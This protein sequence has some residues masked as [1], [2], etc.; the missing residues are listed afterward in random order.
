M[1]T[2]CLVLHKHKSFFA[3]ANILILI[4]SGLRLH[5]HL[6]INLCQLNHFLCKVIMY[7]KAKMQVCDLVSSSSLQLPLVIKHLFLQMIPIAIGLISCLSG[8]EALTLMVSSTSTLYDIASLSHALCLYQN[9]SLFNKICHLLTAFLSQPQR[10][11]TTYCWGR[12]SSTSLASKKGI[13]SS[14]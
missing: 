3:T 9:C 1:K 8:R 4:E 5:L 6:Q 13:F 2:A 10:W 14:K 12:Q 7:H 11:L